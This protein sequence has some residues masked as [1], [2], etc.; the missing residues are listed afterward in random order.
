MASMSGRSSRST[1]MLTNSSFITRGRGRVLEALVR[2]HVAPVAGGVA[3]REQDRLVGALGLGERLRPPRPPVDG[4]VLV[5]QQVGAGL[6]GEAVLGPSWRMSWSR[7]APQDV[8]AKSC[9]SCARRGS[10]S[11]S[12]AHDGMALTPSHAVDTEV[13]VSH[14]QDAIGKRWSMATDTIFALVQRARARRRCGHPH[15]GARRRDVLDAMAPPRPKPRV[16]A[17]RRVRHSASG[18]MLDQA[19]V[20]WFA[21]PRSETGEDMAELQVHGGRAVVR[22]CS[23]RIGS[24]PGC[25]L[26]EPGEFAR[27]RLRERQ[28]RPHRASRASPT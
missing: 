19:L 21:A 15:L 25:R 9:K 18:E 6:A 20:L 26:A 12:R 24:H 5:L 8:A 11:S 13:C 28:A 4:V 14:E 7:V 23:R 27:P 2:H 3:D 16:A 17:L 1:L 22:P 10:G